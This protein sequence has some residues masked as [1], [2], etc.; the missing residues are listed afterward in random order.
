MRRELM[1]CP[2]CGKENPEKQRFCSSCGLKLETVAKALTN[3][4]PSAGQD[5]LIATLRGGNKGW[6]D[7]LV[8]AFGLIAAGMLVG[9]VGYR[10]L[11]EKT[12]GDIGTLVSLVGVL[13]ILLKGIF[14]VIPMSNTSTKESQTV[15]V[16]D[17]AA[18]L[19]AALPSR[20]AALLSAEPPSITEH[21]TKHLEPNA[22]NGTERPR[23]T[24]PTLQ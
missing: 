12:L 17:R 16:P 11:G 14:L 9:A 15:A 6:Q 2:K 7:P 1:Y 23:T 18:N 21:T 13:V 19:P 3:E 4:S 22:E 10:V 8:Y 5:R 20:E 24:Q